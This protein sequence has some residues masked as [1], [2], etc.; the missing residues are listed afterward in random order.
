M[1]RVGIVVLLLFALTGPSHAQIPFHA[2]VD[3]IQHFFKSDAVG[4]DYFAAMTRI[5]DSDLRETGIDMLWKLVLYKSTDVIERYRMTSVYLF[6]DTHL[7]DSVTSRMRYIWASVPVNPLY[8]EHDRVLYYTSLYLLTERLGENQ[9][10]FNGKSSAE[11]HDDAE[12]FLHAWMESVTEQGQQEFDSPTYGSLFITSTL[13]LHRFSRQPDMRKRAEIMTTWLLADYAHEYLGGYFGGAHAREDMYSAMQ[14]IAS[15]MSALAWLYFGDGPQ[16]YSREQLL[17]TFCDYRI[18]E[19]VVELAVNKL[20]P[21][22]AIEMKRSADRIRNDST[23]NRIIAKYTYVDPIYV[24]GSIRGDVTQFR[25]Q[26]TW[27]ATWPSE[28]NEST[29]FTMQPYAEPEGLM[30]FLP[31]AP[32]RLKRLVSQ[33]DP[34]F[35]TITKTVGGSPYENIFQ[36]R[37]TVI[38]LYDIPDIMRFPSMIGFFPNDVA[39]FEIDSL[40]SRWITINAGDVYI[41]YYPFQPFRIFPED[42]GRRL[43]SGG[44]RNGAVIQ[45]VGR[46]SIASFKEFQKRVKNTKVDLSALKTSGRVRYTT[47][48][49]DKLECSFQGPLLVNGKEQRF[50]QEML[51]QSPLLHCVRGSG[52]LRI[53]SRNGTLV[54]DMRKPGIFQE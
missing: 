5:L 23:R 44:G 13:L 41:A 33:M 53:A 27:D 3:S 24:V 38:A 39:T 32:D 52:V 54:L 12:S 51:F 14:P 10:W 42:L 28:K 4:E 37:N 8:D 21:F 31:H 45:I 6:T 11:N 19:E 29:V 7:P 30:D 9:S 43:Y 47:M 36:F 49:R 48:F 25:E 46:N 15:D 2:R 26:H 20:K 34:Y 18:P 1:T 40:R 22:E 50:D 16:M 17:A 35:A